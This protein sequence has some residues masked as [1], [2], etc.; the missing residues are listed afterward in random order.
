MTPE[1]ELRLRELEQK[2]TDLKESQ[3][4]WD[5][6]VRLPHEE[7]LF[8]VKRNP[9]PFYLREALMTLMKRDPKK[10]QY[11]G[12]DQQLLEEAGAAADTYKGSGWFGIRSLLVNFHKR[13]V[14][15]GI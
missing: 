8:L 15:L 11:P 10:Y 5:F 12:N 3:D 1:Q 14:A 4:C 2:V 9:D 13:C 6:F 7:R